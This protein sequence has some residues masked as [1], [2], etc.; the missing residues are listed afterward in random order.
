MTPQKLGKLR[1][2]RIQ[3][4]PEKKGDS[5]EPFQKD[6]DRILYSSALRRLDSITQVISPIDGPT[7]HNRLTHAVKVAQLSRRIAER[8]LSEMKSG[9]QKRMLIAAGGLHPEV[10]DAAGLAH[11]LGHPPFGHVAEKVLNEKA[12]SC[13]ESLKDGFEGNA[14]SFRIV[15]KLSV[16]LNTES[17]NSSVKKWEEGLNLTRATLNSLLKYPWKHERDDEIKSKKWGYYS[18]EQEIFDWVKKGMDHLGDRKTLEAEIMD[19]ADDIAYSVHDTEDFFRLGKIPL[20]R[21]ANGDQ[22]ELE[23]FFRKAENNLREYGPAVDIERCK[24][25]FKKLMKNYCSIENPYYGTPTDRARLKQWASFLTGTYAKSISVHNDPSGQ[26]GTVEIDEAH[27][28]Q[29]IILKQLTWVYV[30]KDP[31]LATVQEGQ[32]KIVETL[33][34]CLMENA[35]G[36]DA[37]T[38]LFP[39]SFRDNL[40]QLHD[41]GEDYEKL[42]ARVVVDYIASMTETEATTLYKRIMGI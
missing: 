28:L 13:D 32:K 42:K 27:R 3:S 15:T 37:N 6:R 31:D 16:R 40:E 23:Y 10:C 39:P 19:W 11:D 4:V 38:Y 34:D 35:L 2:A 20:D 1:K 12:R 7:V 25:L 17:L 30:I 41:K 22:K 33:F 21:L 5:R 9:E 29:T 24:L 8:I 18:Q 36:K 14:Q 26:N